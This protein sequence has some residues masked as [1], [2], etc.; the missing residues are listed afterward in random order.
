M[1]ANRIFLTGIAMAGSCLM[2]ATTAWIYVHK[3]SK[4]KT[5]ELD[6]ELATA[7]TTVSLQ[8]ESDFEEIRREASSQIISMHEE[9]LEFQLARWK[10]NNPLLQKI[11][12]WR[13]QSGFG[14]PPTPNS[15]LASAQA[16]WDKQT[17]A[18]PTYSYKEGNE[19]V[20]DWDVGYFEENLEN[21][22]Y[23]G[24]TPNPIID[25]VPIKSGPSLQ[26]L[27]W[28]RLSDGGRVRGFFVD[29]H[30]LQANLLEIARAVTPGQMNIAII[31]DTSTDAK[32][33]HSLTLPLNALPGYRLQIAY[34]DSN[35]YSKAVPL[36]SQLLIATSLA[37]AL[38]SCIMIVRTSTL[39]HREALRKTNFVSLVS[40]ELKTPL[41]SISMYAELV[42]VCTLSWWTSQTSHQ[43]SATSSHP[44]SAAKAIASE[45]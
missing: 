4:R 45:K 20:F 3:E 22:N 5:S 12:I 13:P 28:H 34:L 9:G 7:L 21:V 6:S 1:K 27:C 23:S 40:H 38:A 35:T 31:A 39:R 11:F 14:T 2:L 10:N 24:T 8:I 29:T 43:K 42:E 30:E 36:V 32:A 19:S 25:W 18:E 17:I 26:W 15:T 41:T 44:P 33:G 37:L 16:I